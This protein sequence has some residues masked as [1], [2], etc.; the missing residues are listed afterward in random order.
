MSDGILLRHHICV[1]VPTMTVCTNTTTLITKGSTCTCTSVYVVTMAP[2]TIN[3]TS[4]LRPARTASKT[5]RLSILQSGAGD[6]SGSP[7]DLVVA[8]VIALFVLVAI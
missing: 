2:S 8:G 4:T 6:L 1:A 7:F 5:T 3:E